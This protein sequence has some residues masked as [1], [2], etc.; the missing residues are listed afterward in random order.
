MLGASNEYRKMI[1]G[2]KPDAKKHQTF[3]DVQSVILETWVPTHCMIFILPQLLLSHSWQARRCGEGRG[4]SSTCSW[5]ASIASPSP[6]TWLRCLCPPFGW[7]RSVHL[8][9]WPLGSLLAWLAIVTFTGYSTQWRNGQFLQEET[10]QH[11]QDPGHCALGGAL[12]RH[13]RGSSGRH[14]LHISAGT[15]DGGSS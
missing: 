7:K 9:V 12:R 3:V 5:R 13:R 4:C 15:P 8:T 6:R 14:L 2:L 11:A 10:H 1:R